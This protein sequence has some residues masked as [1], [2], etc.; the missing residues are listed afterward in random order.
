MR[1]PSPVPPPDPYTADPGDQT[2]ARFDPSTLGFERPGRRSDSLSPVPTGGMPRALREAAEQAGMDPLAELFNEALGYAQENHLRLARERLQMLLYMAPDDGEARLLLAQVHVAD[3]RWQEALQA[4]DEARDSGAE[5]PRELRR[6]VEEQVLAERAYEE[7]QQAALHARTQGETASLRNEVRRLRGENAELAGQVG[8]MQREV[9]K[10]TW[11]TLSVSVLAI[12]AVAAVLWLGNGLSAS[13]APLPVAEVAA[14]TPPMPTQPSPAPPSPAVVPVPPSVPA[15]ASGDDAAGAPASAQPPSELA[16]PDPVVVDEFRLIP[17]PAGREIVF[18]APAPAPSP[19]KVPD[20][21]PVPV[22]V[23][24]QT[25]DPEPAVDPL[26]GARAAIAATGAEI[27]LKLGEPGVVMVTGT[28]VDFAQRKQVER[29]LEALQEV[30]EVHF[31]GSVVL[32]RRDGTEHLVGRGDTLS[33]IAWRYYGN[34]AHIEPLEKANGVT[35]E[36]LRPGM[37]LRVPALP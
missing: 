37:K 12:G 33:H 7:E 15:D 32:S 26:A 16:D 35:A 36:S 3:H 8:I 34:S 11:A 2:V 14:P 17:E 5:V 23:P 4:L 19:T 18:E 1:P 28:F 6:A 9:R 31:G 10:W 25:P 24:V 20:I 27:G 29:A 13:P 22:P 21:L 30:R